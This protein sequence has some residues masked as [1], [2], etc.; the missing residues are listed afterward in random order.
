[1][2]TYLRP[3]TL[4]YTMKTCSIYNAIGFQLIPQPQGPFTYEQKTQHNYMGKS[5]LEN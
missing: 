4:N 1:M 3:R 5:T 2:T